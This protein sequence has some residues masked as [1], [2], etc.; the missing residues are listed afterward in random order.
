MAITKSS[1]GHQIDSNTLLLYKM[2]E[3]LTGSYS[4]CV[5]E[6]GVANFTVYGTIPIFWGPAGSSQRDVFARYFQDQGTGTS[7][8]KVA[9]TFETIRAAIVE[10]GVDHT[11]EFLFTS[12]IE[13]AVFS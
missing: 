7:F 2:G 8:G 11:W 6:K 13:D 10:G 9:G 4:S 1:L 3:D 12:D 5:D